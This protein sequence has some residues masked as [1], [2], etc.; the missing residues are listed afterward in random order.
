MEKETWQD[1]VD[2]HKLACSVSRAISEVIGSEINMADF[3]NLKM[4]ESDSKKVKDLTAKYLKE[5]D[6]ETYFK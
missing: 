3:L 4:K 2:S 1:R 5:T 6:W